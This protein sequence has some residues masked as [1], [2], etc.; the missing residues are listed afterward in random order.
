M[1]N[2]GSV[3]LDKAQ[4][5]I[6]LVPNVMQQPSVPSISYIKFKVEFLLLDFKFG[7]S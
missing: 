7:S 5:Y 6:P 1:L 2:T 3:A 4:A